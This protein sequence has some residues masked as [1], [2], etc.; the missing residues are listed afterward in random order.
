MILLTSVNAVYEVTGRGAFLMLSPWD[1][2]VRIHLQ[3]RIQLRTPD[4]VILNTHVTAVEVAYGGPGK[5]S[6]V[7]GLPPDHTRSDIP[8]GT[9]VGL[10]EQTAT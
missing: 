1:V 8:A 7:I 5:H 2:D 4:G 9:E 3:D 10:V 6:L